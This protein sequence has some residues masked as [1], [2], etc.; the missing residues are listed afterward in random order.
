VFICVHL[1]PFL[2]AGARAEKPFPTEGEYNGRMPLDRRTLFR[3]FGAAGLLGL[4]GARQQK[5]QEQ[6]AAA[7]RALPIPNIKDIGVIECQPEG[8]RLTVVK[9]TTDQNGSTGTAAPPSRNAPTW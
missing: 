7:T 5:A 3:N 8:V 1:W 6:A 9:I 4:A 2:L